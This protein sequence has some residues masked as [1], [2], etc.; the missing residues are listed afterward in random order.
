M[1]SHLGN[2]MLSAVEKS[3]GLADVQVKMKKSAHA[4]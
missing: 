4:D 3:A 1:S 2:V